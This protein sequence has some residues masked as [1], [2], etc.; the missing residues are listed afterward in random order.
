VKFF[1]GVLP[2]IV[3][4]AEAVFPVSF[5]PFHDEATEQKGSG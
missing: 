4:G 1:R 5:A 3:D 2:L